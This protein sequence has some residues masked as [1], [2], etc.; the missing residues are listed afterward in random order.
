MTRPTGTSPRAAAAP[1]IQEDL[2]DEL[3]RAAPIPPAPRPA[4]RTAQPEARPRPTAAD[5]TTVELHVA[6]QR[7]SPPRVS[8]HPGRAGLI[9]SIGPVRLSLRLSPGRARG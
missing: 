9:A 5:G 8:G 1:S 6:P 7:W 3:R 2:L 4:P